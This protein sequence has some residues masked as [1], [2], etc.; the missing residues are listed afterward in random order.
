MVT[1]KHN[2]LCLRA[3]VY[4]S[5]IVG[6][7]ALGILTY[8]YIIWSKENHNPLVI[9]YLLATSMICLNSIFTV[10]AL[11]LEFDI[12]PDYIRYACGLSGGF[13]PGASIFSTPLQITYILSFL[14]TWIATA[15][16][17]YSYYNKSNRLVYCIAMS[18]PILYFFS[19]I[20]P[21]VII[22][23]LITFGTGLM[24]ELST[25]CFHILLNPVVEFYSESHSGACQKA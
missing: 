4:I 13:A 9:I 15:M 16:L 14:F 23:S 12:R 8:K 22:Y 6:F 24:R 7:V 20:Q 18:V 3:A 17:L 2:V 19:L 5:Y 25:L 11:N 10:L 21:F 1:A